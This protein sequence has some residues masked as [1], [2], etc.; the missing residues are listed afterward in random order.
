MVLVSL[1]ELC[2]GYWTVSPA[3]AEEQEHDIDM[4]YNQC[5]RSSSK[6]AKSCKVRLSYLNKLSVMFSLLSSCFLC[7]GSVQSNWDE[8]TL[9]G[10]DLIDMTNLT[11]IPVYFH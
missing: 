10:S 11:L 6:T 5:C 9:S 7:L 8:G 2:I 4:T 3:R 1:G